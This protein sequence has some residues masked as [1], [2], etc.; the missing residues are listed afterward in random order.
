MVTLPK[1]KDLQPPRREGEQ[2]ENTAAPGSGGPGET[3]WGQR[4]KRP[5]EEGGGGHRSTTPVTLA[6]ANAEAAGG[7]VACSATHC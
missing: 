4:L 3:G 2:A 5:H 7:C 6:H 1:A